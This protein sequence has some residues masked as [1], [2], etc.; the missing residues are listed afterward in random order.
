M[1]QIALLSP[2]YCHFLSCWARSFFS[3]IYI[4][5]F[6]R[7]ILECS[8]FAV[9]ERGNVALTNF[10]LPQVECDGVITG[11]WP[12][13]FFFPFFILRIIVSL[14]WVCCYFVPTEHLLYFFILCFSYNSGIFSEGETAGVGRSNTFFSLGSEW[15]QRRE[16]PVSMVSVVLFHT[17]RTGNK[18]E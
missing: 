10:S 4:N 8:C 14:T 5:I 18:K 11:F 6:Y 16:F 12:F 13:S 2:N 7:I 3:G 17:I 1:Y 15:K 9:A